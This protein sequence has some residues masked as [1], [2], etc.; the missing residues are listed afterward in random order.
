MSELERIALEMAARGCVSGL[1]GFP[2]DAVNA[3][4]SGACPRP[5]SGPGSLDSPPPLRP[6][7]TLS[8]RRAYLPGTDRATAIADHR[9]C[10]RQCA[11]V[12]AEAKGKVST[13]VR[14][15]K[16]QCHGRTAV[17]RS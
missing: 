7:G 17:A 12:E 8:F 9:R 3:E 10:G 5:P 14:P 13:C 2:L 1:G 16:T 11:L 6:W 15:T 4:W